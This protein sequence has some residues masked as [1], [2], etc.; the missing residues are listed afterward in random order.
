MKAN[1]HSRAGV[2]FQAQRV[3]WDIYLLWILSLI[4]A[5]IAVAQMIQRV[6]CHWLVKSS[7]CRLGEML[8]IIDCAPSLIY[9]AVQWSWFA[10]V[11]AL[12]NLS[13]KKSWEFAASLPGRF[14][15]RRCFTLQWK[16]NLELQS[17]TNAATVAVAKITGERG[18][19]VEEKCIVYS[20]WPEDREFMEKMCFGA[21]YSTSNKLLLV[22]RHILTTGL[23]KCL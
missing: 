4:P 11:N 1:K 19:R 2:N 15:S 20:G 21:S 22:A 7:D 23:Q 3:A 14:L 16:L 5:H 8:Y 9:W 13:R 12:C 10:R 6:L 18:W 17:S